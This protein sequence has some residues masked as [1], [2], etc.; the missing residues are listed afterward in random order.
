M[1]LFFIGRLSGSL[2][3]M[4]FIRPQILLSFYSMANCILLVFV[5]SELRW[6]SVI[7]LCA[8]YFFESIMFPTIFALSIGRLSTGNSERKKKKKWKMKE[9]K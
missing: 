2:F 8:V 6:F 7:C 1:G 9:K 5:V 4:R 3:F